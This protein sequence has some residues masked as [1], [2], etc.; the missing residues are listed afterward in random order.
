MKFLEKGLIQWTENKTNELIW[1]FPDNK[2]FWEDEIIV[3]KNQVAGIFTGFKLFSH[4]KLHDIITEGKKII[5]PDNLKNL[6]Y[7]EIKN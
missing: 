5:L 7:L 6:Y 2:V 3:G 4:P 1:K